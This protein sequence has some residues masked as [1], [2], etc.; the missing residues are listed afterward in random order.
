MLVV[1]AQG[2]SGELRSGAAR[3]WRGFH[4]QGKATPGFLSV[5]V[6]EELGFVQLLDAV[7][8]G[9]TE[10]GGWKVI[11]SSQHTES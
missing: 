3:A 10:M 1:V 6:E 7:V 9:V 2:A 11:G 5:T 4:R 8:R